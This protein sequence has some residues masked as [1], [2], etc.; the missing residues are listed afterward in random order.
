MCW[1]RTE[2]IWGCPLNAEGEMMRIQLDLELV[3]QR[4]SKCGRVRYTET[5]DA[6][7]NCAGIEI[8]NRNATIKKLNRA[9][10]VYRSLLKRRGK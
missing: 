10:S 9:I 8:A 5:Y 1:S 2:K 4:C 6:C 3:Q 7:S